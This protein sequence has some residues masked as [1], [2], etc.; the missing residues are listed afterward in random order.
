MVENR[1]FFGEN[2]SLF[3][4]YNMKTQKKQKKTRRFLVNLPPGKLVG[5]FAEKRGS[6]VVVPI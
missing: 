5:E 1:D 6:S 2:N 3:Y 4:V